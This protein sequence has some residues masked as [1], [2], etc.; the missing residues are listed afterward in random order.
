ME[1]ILKKKK[2]T[3]KFIMNSISAIDNQLVVVQ[4]GRFAA[5]EVLKALLSLMR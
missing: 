3:K 4:A 2:N 5:S 1:A